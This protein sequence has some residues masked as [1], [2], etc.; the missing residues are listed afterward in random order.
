MYSDDEIRQIIL[1]IEEGDRSPRA[2]I[3]HL[4]YA[5]K[6]P[7]RYFWEMARAMLHENEETSIRTALATI[8]ALY[9][10]GTPDILLDLFSFLNNPN[11]CADAILVIARIA[12][13]LS[14]ATVAPRF[15]PFL[16]N[17]DSEIR[18]AAFQGILGLKYAENLDVCLHMLNDEDAGMRIIACDALGYMK[19]PI[20][21]DYLLG[22][23]GDN[24]TIEGT[25]RT[26]NAS[27][28][29]AL[30]YLGDKRAIE[31]LKN[32]VLYGDTDLSEKALRALWEIE[33]TSLELFY[34]EQVKHSYQETRRAAIEIL[35]RLRKED[36]VDL[37]I[38]ISQNDLN[39]GVQ[40]T[41]AYALDTIGTTKAKEAYENWRK[42]DIKRKS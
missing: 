6:I 27:A 31:P 22:K 15:L 16:F 17:P 18:Y 41:A 29:R 38:S 7:L 28:A 20:A 35:G 26:V 42:E 36:Y 39:D 10:F 30:G 8:S 9:K 34:F 32:A 37:L 40:F 25:S 5:M 1:K 14:D 4:S 2:K 3:Y 19:N 23:L 12:E 21:V 24:E 11:H 33:G 13:K